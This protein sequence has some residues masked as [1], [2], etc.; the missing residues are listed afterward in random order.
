MNWFGF[1]MSTNATHILAAYRLEQVL[2]EKGRERKQSF[3]LSFGLLCLAWPSACHLKERLVEVRNYLF[4]AERSYSSSI[5]S[6]KRN[7]K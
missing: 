7:A 3:Q 6:R 1:F 5:E 4:G 2:L